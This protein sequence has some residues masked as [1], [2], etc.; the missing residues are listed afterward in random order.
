MSALTLSWKAHNIY[1]YCLS[2]DI[3][4]KNQGGVDLIL[5]QRGPRF[6][7]QY[8]C[9]IKEVHGSCS[10]I[11]ARSKRSTVHVPVF[12][13]DCEHYLVYLFIT[14]FLFLI[15]RI[16][17]IG[18]GLLSVAEDLMKTLRQTVKT[19]NNKALKYLQIAYYAALIFFFFMPYRKQSR[20]KLC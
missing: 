2:C 1:A 17:S 6:M 4:S 8:S 3:L 9:Q 14:L 20:I 18:A 15:S 5:N 16:Q 13:P 12:V 10:S 7:F 19:F 11:C